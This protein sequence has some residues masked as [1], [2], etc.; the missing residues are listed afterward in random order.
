MRELPEMKS[1][2]KAKKFS[3]KFE[4]AIHWITWIILIHR[5]VKRMTS[6]ERMCSH[7]DDHRWQV[8][9]DRS[10]NY[11]HEWK[12]GKVLLHS[13]PL[14]KDYCTT[15]QRTALALCVM[16]SRKPRKHYFVVIVP[17]TFAHHFTRIVASHW[18]LT[19]DGFDRKNRVEHWMGDF[20]LRLS[21][22]LLIHFTCN[23]KIFCVQ[24]T[25]AEKVVLSVVLN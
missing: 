3:P 14:Q 20:E 12:T 13:Y 17:C 1:K 5:H 6:D 9:M 21:W 4:W 18:D 15:I 23:L 22:G 2:R 8:C 11:S 16:L 24:D 7:A 25:P 19:W 10:S